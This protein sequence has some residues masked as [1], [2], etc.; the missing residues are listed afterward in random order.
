MT[1]ITNGYRWHL[2]EH[3]VPLEASVLLCIYYVLNKTPY[4]ST[5]GDELGSVAMK[6]NGKFN[7]ISIH[8]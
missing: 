7:V 1:Q 2:M 3:F 6:L 8:L 5:S 4:D